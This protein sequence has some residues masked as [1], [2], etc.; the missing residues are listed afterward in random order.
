[1][2]DASRKE[3]WDIITNW[4]VL[5]TISPLVA[6][7]VEY[8]GDQLIEGSHLKL[9]YNTNRNF[10]CDFKIVTVRNDVYSSEDWEYFME[11]CTSYPKIP[12]QQIKFSIV[13]LE[14]NKCFLTFTH[15]YKEKLNVN[16]LSKISA[17]KKIVLRDI[18][19]YLEK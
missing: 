11:L 6:D 1:M 12:F 13:F 18:K 17:D 9:I 2:I 19:N 8:V 5:R 7:E 10:V 4:C 3:I 16:M 15:E 14:S